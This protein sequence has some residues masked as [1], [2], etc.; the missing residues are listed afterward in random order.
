VAEE[1]RKHFSGAGET[2][3]SERKI[4][5]LATDLSEHS[6]TW[7]EKIFAPLEFTRIEMIDL[8]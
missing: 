5:F 8:V 4:Q 6:K 7:A 1:M 2:S 3:S